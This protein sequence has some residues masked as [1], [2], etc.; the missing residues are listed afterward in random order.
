LT[1]SLDDDRR[2]ASELSLIWEEHDLRRQRHTFHLWSK[3]AKGLLAEVCR[4]EGFMNDADLVE[5][6]E[7][8]EL[9][10]IAQR[11]DH[12]DLAIMFLAVHDGL[13]SADLFTMCVRL[14]QVARAA[15]KLEDES[16]RMLMDLADA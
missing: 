9:I 5:T 11:I 12:V 14:R 10:D 16:N 1:T 7:R 8:R 13:L 6:A 3:R 2:F 15:R 4:R